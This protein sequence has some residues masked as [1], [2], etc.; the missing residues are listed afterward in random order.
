MNF[1]VLITENHVRNKSKTMTKARVFVVTRVN[2]VLK[3]EKKGTHLPSYASI[4]AQS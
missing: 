4:R 1:I 3:R 2:S